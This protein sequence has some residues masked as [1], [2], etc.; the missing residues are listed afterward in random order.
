M[1][2]TIKWWMA[3]DEKHPTCYSRLASVPSSSGRWGKFLASLLLFGWGFNILFGDQT[4]LEW[5]AMQSIVGLIGKCQL[6]WWL[7]AVGI[8]PMLGVA[9]DWLLISVIG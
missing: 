5:E 3:G 4:M 7:L 1:S 6:G 9:T 2:D 8:L